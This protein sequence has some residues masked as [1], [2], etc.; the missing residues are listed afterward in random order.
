MNSETHLT[1]F[2]QNTDTKDWRAAVD[3]LS[4]DVHEVD[5]AAVQIW[6]A[7][8]PLDLARLFDETDDA[9]TLA[10]ELLMQGDFRLQDQI[11]S[12]HTFLYGHRF[13]PEV[14]KAVVEYVESNSA[15]PSQTLDRHIRTVTKKVAATTKQEESLLLGITIIA[16]MTLAQVGLEKLK[17]AP[18]T[19]ALD[20]AQKRKSPEQILKE[21]A[22]NDNQGV[23]GFLRTADKQWTVV[24]DENDRTAKFKVIDSEELASGAA[25]DQSR[26]WRASDQRRIE[27][28]IPVECRSAACGTCWV[29]VLGGAEKLSEVSRR[30]GTQ[31]KQFGYINTDEAKPLIRLACM[32]QASGAVS[33]VIPPWNGVFGKYL[34]KRKET[35]EASA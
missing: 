16:F 19:I 1:S 11:D 34:Q 12:S 30:E 31:I 17:N 7:F 23:F 8:F 33:I 5:A 22:R 9:A 27:G 14:K 21:R 2:L 28:P 3:E 18:G 32:A 25:R 29:G 26:D 6:L 13:W 24:F 20:A 4:P 35:L 10:R 15:N